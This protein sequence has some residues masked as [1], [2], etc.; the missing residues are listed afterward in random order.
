MKKQSFYDAF[1]HLE[2]EKIKSWIKFLES[3]VETGAELMADMREDD[4]DYRHNPDYWTME[5][6]QENSEK[7]LNKF[8]ALRKQRKEFVE[9]L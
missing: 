4:P 5:N 3:D 7:L 1:G 8:L 6:A 2:N 9:S